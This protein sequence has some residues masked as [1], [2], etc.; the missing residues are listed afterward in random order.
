MET[1]KIGGY[2]SLIKENYKAAKNSSI[3][4]PQACAGAIR[5]ALEAAVKLLWLKKYNKEPI[6]VI[7]GKEGFNLYEAVKDSRFS[8]LFNEIIISDIHV[9]RRMCNDVLHAKAPFTVGVAQELLARLEKC[10][11]A[12]QSVIEI[13]VITKS[14]VLI[15]NINIDMSNN[16]SQK[17]ITH[18]ISSKTI[19]NKT[20]K[21]IQKG[22]II[23]KSGEF[24]YAKTHAE[25]LNKAFG[26]NYKSWMRSAWPYDDEWVVWM[27]QFNKTKNGWRNIFVS[28]SCIKQEN[29]NA[30]KEFDGKPIEESTT[31]K[32]IVF[33]VDETGFSRKYIFKGKFVYDEDRSNP[34]TSQYLNKISDSF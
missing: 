2:I 6:W 19:F 5:T 17:Q 29:L 14:D 28:D 32:R 25:F 4:E 16:I 3:Q 9:I 8:S 34:L 30:V 23:M 33:E 12:I 7:N 10:V 18:D 15:Q 13:D 24:I 27:V 26:T 11:E 22:E 31:K 21:N 1:N 20:T